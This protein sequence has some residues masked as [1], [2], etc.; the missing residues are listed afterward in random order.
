MK[1]CIL[2]KKEKPGVKEVISFTKTFID[3][4]DVFFGGLNDPFPGDAKKNHYDILISYI[5]P[6]I[7][8]VEILEKTKKWNINFHP[9]PPEYP[10]IGCLNFAIF[11]KAKQ[12]L[13]KAIEIQP[14]NVSAF[15]NLGTAYKELGDH[16]RAIN[17]YNKKNQRN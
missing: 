11:D 4:C 5:S 15:N 17:Y 12:L 14:E 13:H 9:G 10:G 8:P 6:W 3:D 16:K 2:T 1:I 7:V